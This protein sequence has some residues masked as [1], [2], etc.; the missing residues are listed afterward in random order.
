MMSDRRGRPLAQYLLIALVTSLLFN[1]YQYERR[2][3]VNGWNDDKVEACQRSAEAANREL[4]RLGQNKALMEFANRNKNG[5]GALQDTGLVVAA[6]GGD[7]SPVGDDHVEHVVAAGGETYNDEEGWDSYGLQRVASKTDNTFYNPAEDA[8]L[9]SAATRRYARS[10]VP[11]GSWKVRVAPNKMVT[12]DEVCF[13]YDVWFEENQVFQYMSWMGVYVQQDPADA[14]AIQ[15]MLWKVKPDLVIEVGTNT[16]GGAIFYATIMKAYNPHAKIVTLDV[17]PEPRNWNV[18]NAH[19]CEN[20]T[21]IQGHPWWNDGMITYIQGRVTERET[22]DK[23][24]AFV[25]KAKTV[26]VIEDASHRYPDT[27]R[28]IEAIHQWVTPGSYLLVQD[29]KMDRFVAGLGKRYGNLKFGPMRSVDEFLAKHKDEFVI[30]RR[31][32]YLLYSQH[33]RGYL[34]RK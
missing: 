14:F 15:Q 12:M 4:Y 3:I 29:T 21:L 11:K 34:R 22:R 20:C 32:E 9:Q 6:D 13:A 5:G 8:Q 25:R 17:V 26:L 27:L 31:F 24:D 18:K 23:V 19:R 16:G 30:D 10:P 1:W 2:N 7:D 33:H 28:N